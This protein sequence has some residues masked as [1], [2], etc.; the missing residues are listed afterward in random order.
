MR[1]LFR[2]A[3]VD[4][5]LDRAD[6]SLVVVAESGD[7]AEASSA[8]LATSAWRVDE[9]VVLRHVLRLPAQR[10]PDAVATAAL[11]GYRR[12]D[13][14]PDVGPE[15]ADANM[16]DPT[17]TVTL[18]RVQMLD[19][20]HLSQERSRMASLGSRHGGLV[21]GWQVLQRPVGDR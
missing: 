16:A 20:V 14:G 7:E 15:V 1:N 10:V 6:T 4:E 5:P 8:V 17:V 3:A 19:A 11:S 18:A 13:S 21:V 9:E 12:L 2:P